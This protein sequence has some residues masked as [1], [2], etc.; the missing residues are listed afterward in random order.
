MLR[1]RDIMTREV[2]TVSPETRIG[3]ATRLLLE[4]RINGVP[5]VD[6]TG[7]LV[8]ILCQSDLIAQQKQLPM[9]SLFTLLDA[10][11]PLRSLKQLEKQVEKIAAS[12]VAQAMTQAPVTVDPDTPVDQLAA[13]M[14]DRKFHT[15]PV[16]SDGRLVGVVGKEDVLKTLAMLPLKDRSGSPEA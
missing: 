12:T 10:M 14:V 15:L 16:L 4:R 7:R 2:L 13:L 8:G 6:D 1:A 9:P 11:I 3:D 5:V